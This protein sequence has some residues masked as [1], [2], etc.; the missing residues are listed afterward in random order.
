M[1]Q[2]SCIKVKCLKYPICK[3]NRY[4]ECDVLEKFCKS[5]IKINHM[6]KKRLWGMI[7]ITLPKLEIF[8]IKEKLAIGIVSSF[9]CK[10]GSKPR[11]YS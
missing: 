10:P 11:L 6:S 2:L 5:I 3:Q 1:Q 7:N 9:V 8:I 4:V